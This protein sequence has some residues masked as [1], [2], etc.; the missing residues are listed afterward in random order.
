MLTTAQA[1]RKGLKYF[2][3]FVWHLGMFGD[4]T[5]VF[6]WFV[7]V[8]DRFS[9]QWK[10]W[11]L[12]LSMVIGIAVS[13]V[14]HACVYR[15][16]PT[17][18]AHAHDG[19]LTVAGWLHFVYMGLG[20]GLAIQFYLFTKAASGYVIITSL[21]FGIHMTLATHVLPALWCKWTGEDWWPH[22]PWRDKGAIIFV[23][24]LWSVLTAATLMK[25]Y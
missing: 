22:R 1:K 11:Q 3:P 16:A 25:I 20:N 4:A 9:S 21:M 18:E 6:V 17:P 13:A 19:K 2:L 7:D 8:T 23:I 15:K 10:S 14:L 12:L 5:Y 24:I